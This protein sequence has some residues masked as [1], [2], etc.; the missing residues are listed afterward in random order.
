MELMLLI[1][2]SKWA[3]QY[4]MWKYIT[5]TTF[6]HLQNAENEQSK[7]ALT[8]L[9]FQTHSEYNYEYWYQYWY[10]NE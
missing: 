2:A 9:F 6:L 4:G 1:K 10:Q 7:D 3:P 5:Q 8:P